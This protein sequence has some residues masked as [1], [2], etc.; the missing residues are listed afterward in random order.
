MAY[1]TLILSEFHIDFILPEATAMI[2]LL[3]CIHRSGRVFVPPMNC[4]SNPLVCRS[5]PT[6][7]SP[8]KTESTSSRC[9]RVSGSDCADWR[10]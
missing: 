1:P 4:S 2:A 6:L 7:L 8:G 3:Y 9:P 10:A 5:R